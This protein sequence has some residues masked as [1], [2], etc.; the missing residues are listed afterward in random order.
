MTAARRAPRVVLIGPYGTE[1]LGDEA[2]LRLN[3]QLT[4]PVTRNYS[5]FVHLIDEHDVIVAQRDMYPGQGS[6]ALSEQ[7]AG[8]RWSDHY[9]LRLSPLPPAPKRLRWA[10]GLYDLATGERLTLAD[11]S[12]RA[13]FGSVALTPRTS[14]EPLLRY[15]N[16]L[17]LLAYALDPPILAPDGSLTVTT[18]WQALRALPADLNVSLQVLDEGANKIAQRDLGQSLTQWQPGQVVTLTHA[19][20]VDAGATPGVYRLLLVWYAPDDFARLPAYDAQ[21]QFAGDQVELT[22]LRVR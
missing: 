14:T 18:R 11:G 3:W 7:P 8:R 2:T 16:G 12:D 22:R 10:V 15:A 1:N 13:I 20:A 9:T 6:L 21:G 4:Q 17:A 5:V 19:L